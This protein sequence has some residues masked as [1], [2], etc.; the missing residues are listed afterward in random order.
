MEKQ[1][2]SG[3]KVTF[4]LHFVVGLL[5]G[6]VMLLVPEVMGTM[7]GQPIVEPIAYRALG[8]A[9][10]GFAASSW[11]SY[12]ETLWERVKIVVQMEIVWPFLFVVVAIYGILTG[13][14]P[15]A[16]WVNVVIVGGFGIAFAYFY[17]KHR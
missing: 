4:L 14:L 5:F 13:Q 15:T 9:I 7:A 2:S 6:L 12:R 8:A 11:W 17:S 10:L 3:L 16:D 1:I